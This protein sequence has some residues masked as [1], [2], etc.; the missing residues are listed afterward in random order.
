MIDKYLKG[1]IQKF[2][3]EKSCGEIYATGNSEK[4]YYESQ[5]NSRN[6]LEPS[7]ISHRS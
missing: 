4:E 5:A 6:K 1:E 7:S 2:W 3:N